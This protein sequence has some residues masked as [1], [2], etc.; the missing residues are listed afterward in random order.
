MK[1]YF[2][3]LFILCQVFQVANAQQSGLRK[4]FGKDKLFKLD[5]G[6]NTSLLYNF[7]SDPNN[8]RDPFTTVIGGNL[9]FFVAGISL[10]VSFSYSNAQVSV[11][12]P[13]NFNRFSISPKYK[14][15]TLHLGTSSTVLS[16]Y[17]LNGF[18]YDG[19]GVDLTPGKLKFKFMSGRLLRG[20]GDFNQNPDVTPFYKRRGTGVAAEYEIKSGV[21]IGGTLFHAKEDSTTASNIPF[22]LA[23]K[24]KENFVATFNT[25]FTI[26]KQLSVTAEVAKNFLTQDLASPL[27]SV[28]GKDVFSGFLNVN[29]TTARQLARNV[30]IGYTWKTID[31]GLEYEKVD[32]GYQCLGAFFN[33]NG[34]ENTLMRLSFPL[35]KNKL[36]L[37]PSFGIQNDL[38]DS[39]SSQKGGRFLTTINANYNPSSKLSFAGSYSNNVSITNFRNLDNIANA[40]NLIPFYLDSVRLVLL[41][42]NLSFNANYQLKSNKDINKSISASYS[43]QNGTK[44]GGEF[45]I[46]EEANQ[47][48]NGTLTMATVFPK[49]TF[50][51]NVSFNYTLSKQGLSTTTTAYGPGFTIGKKFMKKKLL[52]QI[53]STY[54]TTF[55]NETALRVNVMNFNANLSYNIKDRHD[56]KFS[57]IFQTRTS[58]NGLTNINNNTTNGIISLIYNYNF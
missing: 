21:I 46:D 56:F 52:T 36:F 55:T 22:E 57:G 38:T 7:S 23:I 33:Q 50:Q 30:K 12:P 25:K 9:N 3:V 17:S 53:G 48:H 47:F 43:L 37:S 58:I 28:I 1:K 26:L 44:K 19:V 45:F 6:F 40:N 10:P 18:Q 29:G 4:L 14:W 42:M 54:N 5:G 16:P 41:N 15:A 49:T 8:L 20:T 51:Y 32:L 31:M 24:P 2:I 27:K 34:F 13:M 39:V 11:T 35:F